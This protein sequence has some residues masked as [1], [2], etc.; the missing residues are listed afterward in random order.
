MYSELNWTRQEA[1]IPEIL[2]FCNYF[3][4]EDIELFDE[5]RKIYQETEFQPVREKSKKIVELYKRKLGITSEND[6][7][8]LETILEVIGNNGL[9][10]HL[11]NNIDV[12][13]IIENGLD[14]KAKS[15]SVGRL[16]E[17]KNSL[18]KETVGELF[19]YQGSDED[20]YSYSTN[21]RLNVSYGRCPEWLLNLTS[22]AYNTGT[23]LPEVLEDIAELCKENGESP[24]SIETLLKFTE[25]NY[26]KY[27]KTRK[28]MVVFPNTKDID[29]SV[30][31]GMTAEES[32]IMIINSK[33]KGIDERGQ[34]PIL[35]EQ[36]AIIDIN[37]R[38]FDKRIS[39]KKEISTEK[40]GRTTIKTCVAEKMQINEWMQEEVKRNKEEKEYMI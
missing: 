23:E 33:E 19:P 36:I 20:K 7:R 27:L 26:K 12:K 15:D 1:T 34:K 21:P 13:N 40:I 32:C 24:E 9:G 5:Y 31:N 30:F 29:I 4:Q 11:T 35:P 2:E 6:K 14:P 28:E 16:R 25:E 22:Y 3:R 18:S 8:L 10:F 37:S 17:I 38:N 39:K